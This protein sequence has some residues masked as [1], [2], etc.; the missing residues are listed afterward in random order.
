MNSEKHKS[1]DVLTASQ[2]A[3][4]LD[5]SPSRVIRAINSGALVPDGRAG[6]AFIFRAHR[7]RSLG[8]ILGS[9]VE[10]IA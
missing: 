3:R 6:M 9:Q 5:V 1:L 7:M 4:R 8:R 10:V 2:V